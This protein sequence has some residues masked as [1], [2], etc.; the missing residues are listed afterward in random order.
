MPIP[1][2]QKIKSNKRK[3]WT[4]LLIGIIVIIFSIAFLL[5]LPQAQTQQPAPPD[6]AP[7][8]EI[9]SSTTSTV[10]DTTSSITTVA[11]ASTTTTAPIQLATIGHAIGVANGG[12]L[13]KINA[14][15]LNRELDQVVAMGATW[16][17]FDI[18]WGNVQ[19]SSP[20]KSTWGAYDALVAALAAHHLHGLGVISFTPEWARAPGCTNGIECPPADPSTFA[21]FAAQV[22]ARYKNQ[23]MHYWEIWNEPNNFNFWAPKTDCSAYTTLLKA[24]YP[25]V[26]R[27]DP[28]SII[29][30]GG[31]SP[32]ATNDVSI[33]PVD[34]LSCVYKDGGKRYFDAVG[35]H[36]YSYPN[37]PSNDGTGAWNQMAITTPSLRSIMVANGDSNK[38]I[39]LTEYG[40]PTNGPDPHWYVSETQQATMA[41]DALA[42][43]K[44]YS[45]AG[46]LFWYTFVDGGTTTDTNENFFG[47]VRTDG[48]TKPAY[49]TLKALISLGL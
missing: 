15:A 2:I 24:V 36:P 25:A 30:T 23:G 37:F 7:S 39:W 46:P 26:K 22:A 14:N 44:T 31:L 5:N 17:R 10:E 18:E 1:T 3:K 34:F 4:I 6:P 20:D 13:S 47:L 21:T 8:Q 41:A 27:A 16:V 40:T 48:S 38:K 9:T 42:L 19:Y 43:Y 11:Q 33:A 32:Q 35:D 12:T 49:Q 28:N 29:I 45:W